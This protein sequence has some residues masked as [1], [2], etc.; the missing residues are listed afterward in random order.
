MEPGTETV[1]RVDGQVAIARAGITA[2]EREVLA[3][4]AARLTNREIADRLGCSVR[5]VESHVSALLSK[6]EVADRIALARLG[7][8]S[9]S[10]TLPAGQRLPRPV[11]SFVGRKQELAEIAGLL[12]SN[13]VVTLVGPPGVGKTRLAV[14]FVRDQADAGR[15]AV[16]EVVFCDLTS[17]SEDAVV[18]DVVLAGLGASAA[19]DRS[20]LQALRETDPD[21]TALVVIDNCE[22][23]V[24]GAADVVHALTSAAPR[25]RVL[26]TSREP[27][28]VDGE[29][30]YPIRVLGTETVAGAAN[31]PSALSDAV[32]LFADRARAAQPG[33]RLEAADLEPVTEICR[34]LDGLPLAIELAAPRLRAF[35]IRQLAAALDDVLGVL[36]PRG[37]RG[38]SHH[39]TL[40][41]SIEWSHRTLHPAESVLL[42]RM[43]VF[44]GTIGLAAIEAVCAD[45]WLPRREIAGVLASLVD[46]SLVESEATAGDEHRFRL[47]FP[48]RSFA[49]ERAA[50]AGELDELERRHAEFYADRVE[51]AEPNLIGPTAFEWAARLRDDIDDIRA[52]LQWS[53]RSGEL[54]PGLRIVAAIYIFWEDY[55][56]RREWMERVV[57]LVS[58]EQDKTT[59]PLQGRA[60]LVRARALVAASKMLEAWDMRLA[61]AFAQE[62]VELA[63][64]MGDARVLARARVS[65]G[66]LLGRTSDGAAEARRLLDAGY[67]WFTEVGD[68]YGAAGALF[69]LGLREPAALAIPRWARARELYA[70]IGDELGVANM[71]YLSGLRLVREGV[72]LDTAETLLRE[73]VERAPRHG[74]ERETAHA[75]SGLGHLGVV[76]GNDPE[77]NVLIRAALP[78]F[79]ATGDVRCTAR[80][81][82]LLGVAA[83]RAGDREEALRAYR[84][85]IAAAERVEDLVTL[86][87]ALDGIGSVL[88]PDGDRLAIVLH[89]AAA[90]SRN[91]GRRS[92]NV[93]GVDYDASIRERRRRLG[94]SADAAWSEGSAL[95]PLE[96]ARL[97]VE[98]SYVGKPLGAGKG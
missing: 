96:A 43:S 85:A 31:D 82:T 20:S 35:S 77:A 94:A 44:A 15:L 66:T 42:R 38:T 81:E 52:A 73:A 63:E 75:R 98:G 16:S 12:E 9:S 10:G 50:E 29:V 21:S 89:A 87:D 30:T 67:D 46:R 49:R 39:G 61:T 14:E 6:L 8:S 47:L 28:G 64:A 72:E 26:A 2:R 57:D 91:V 4:L 25:L 88:P 79:K 33:F 41:A 68:R 59:F 84:A 97:A 23:V 5:T 62:A 92:S 65:L 74:S 56:R 90:A 95:A 78:V 11:A 71:L 55:D 19:T 60:T 1:E 13:P 37:G 36:A 86:A 69:G 53:R 7:Q 58:V 34:R 83:G 45:E 40:R 24:R 54:E 22:H 80:C 48:I 3:C 93:P 76:R 70:A 27:L 18:A 32:R 51:E 17:L